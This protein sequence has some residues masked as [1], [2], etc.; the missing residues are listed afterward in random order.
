MRYDYF[1]YIP[2]GITFMISKNAKTDHGREK[3]RKCSLNKQTTENW[4]ICLTNHGWIKE[5]EEDSVDIVSTQRYINHPMAF[6]F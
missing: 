6:N 3:H 4:N 5:D 1:S 2:N